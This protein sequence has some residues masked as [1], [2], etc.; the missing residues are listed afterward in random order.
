MSGPIVADRVAVRL[1]A[2]HDS[3][4]G[5]FRNGLTGGSLGKGETTVLRAG[6]KALVTDRLTLVAKGEYLRLT[7]QG[8]PGQNHGLFARN[9]LDLSLD[10]PGSIRGTSRFATA[11]LDWRVGPG[12][13]TNI[14]GWRH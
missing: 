10:N 11:R 12:T 2:F 4:G 1:A 13:L 6:L 3:D 9:G 7:G 14:A 8:A 5:Y